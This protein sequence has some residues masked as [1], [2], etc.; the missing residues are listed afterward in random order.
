MKSRITIGKKL[1]ISLGVVQALTFGLG[2]AA[3]NA[4]GS[5]GREMD[6]AVNRTAV[7]LDLAQAI[8]KRVQE[9]AGG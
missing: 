5:L 1:A 8:G 7:K 3:W 2:Y 9:L 4:I 6:Q